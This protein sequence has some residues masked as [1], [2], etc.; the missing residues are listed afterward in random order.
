MFAEKFADTFNAPYIH[1]VELQKLVETDA[2]A[3]KVANYV[4]LQLMLTRQLII[5]DG[6]GDRLADRREIVKFAQKHGYTPLF[7]WVQTEP[8]TA[9]ARAV[10][11]RTATMTKDQFDARVAEF[12]NPIDKE[13]VLV[14]SGKHAYLSQARSVLKRLAQG[15]PAAPSKP[16]AV[17]RPVPIR[18]RITR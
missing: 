4:L 12:E 8:A 5:I 18:G 11:S 10:H 13:P 14:I 17:Q 6:P 15:A 1:Y 9:E 3:E 7:V 16:A 2:M